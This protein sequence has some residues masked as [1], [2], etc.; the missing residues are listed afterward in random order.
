MQRLGNPKMTVVYHSA[1]I[2]THDP[3]SLD[4][5][6]NHTALPYIT[7]GLIWNSKIRKKEFLRLK[8]FTGQASRILKIFTG[9]AI[10]DFKSKRKQLHMDKL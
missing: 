10:K 6:K 5:P 9:T 4:N 3:I 1:P 2:Y 7:W 8:C